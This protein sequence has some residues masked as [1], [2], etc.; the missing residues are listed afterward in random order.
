VRRPARLHPGRALAQAF[1]VW[2]RDLLLPL[3]IVVACVGPL[4]LLSLLYG[5]ESLQVMAASGASGLLTYS[6]STVSTVA[7]AMAFEDLDLPGADPEFAAALAVGAA[8]YFGQLVAAAAL[9]RRAHRRLAPEVRGVGRIPFVGVLAFGIAAGALFL[10]VD[11]A[12]VTAM[13]EAE[14]FLVILCVAAAAVAKA[15]AACLFWLAL[16]PVVVDR[17]RLGAGLARS[18]RLTSRSR[19]PV[20]ALLVTLVVGHWGANALAIAALGPSGA[21]AAAGV[22]A[23]LFVPVK[24]CTLAAAYRELCLAK[25]G[26]RA[27]EL[28]QVFA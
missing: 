2:R 10:L 13:Q 23:A 12:C 5:D 27:E 9:V 17:E 11:A 25:E 28:R 6:W 26:P 7:F 22:V 18:R 21:L 24:A 16:P 15:W 3:G 19:F 1:R 4:V 14:E 20:F 8:T